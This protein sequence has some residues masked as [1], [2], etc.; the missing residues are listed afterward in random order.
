MCFKGLTARRRLIQPT[1]QMQP[2]AKML[3]SMPTAASGKAIKPETAGMTAEAALPMPCRDVRLYRSLTC[4]AAG[5]RSCLIWEA[6]LGYYAG[7]GYLKTSA[8]MQRTMS[9]SG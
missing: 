5:F 2:P 9:P 1:D 3:L 6:W 7:T 4:L 8:A